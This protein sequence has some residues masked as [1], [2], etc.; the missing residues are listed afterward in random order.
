MG[1]EII[2]TKKKLT[3]SLIEQIPLSFNNS[4]LK[5]AK[6]LGYARING[7]KIMLLKVGENEYR[8]IYYGWKK[9]GDTLIYRSAGIR[10]SHQ[11]GFESQEER[12]L[13]LDKFKKLGSQATQIYV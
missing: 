12:N 13:F 8:K 9:S 1:I 2:T 10:F 5:I 7:H 11:L 6:V 4:E 3:E